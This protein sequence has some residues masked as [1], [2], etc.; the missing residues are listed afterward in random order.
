MSAHVPSTKVALATFLNWT[1]LDLTL[2]VL[3]HPI[4]SND[5]WDIIIFNQDSIIKN[6][7]LIPYYRFWRP[8]IDFSSLGL[9]Y[10]VILTRI[11]YSKT[12]KTIFYI[13]PI[14]ICCQSSRNTGE[15]AAIELKKSLDLIWFLCRRIFIW[16]I[17]I[18]KKQ[19]CY[20][21]HSRDICY[22][23]VLRPCMSWGKGSK[24]Q[25]IEWV[26]V[27]CTIAWRQS[28]ECTLFRSLL[29]FCIFS[30]LPLLET[31]RNLLLQDSRSD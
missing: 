19:K 18:N 24:I 21:Q 27:K 15:I 13:F 29:N 30:S 28:H 8:V 25:C 31:L 3:S 12:K 22:I 11:I 20:S 7:F 23:C 14:C 26:V 6:L 5:H 16:M 2:W 9:S 10:I 4:W 1:W 17:K